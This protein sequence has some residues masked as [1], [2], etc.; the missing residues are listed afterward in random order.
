MTCEKKLYLWPVSSYRKSIR[1][2]FVQPLSQ[3]GGN[4]TGRYSR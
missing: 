2:D 3:C 1:D 4:L